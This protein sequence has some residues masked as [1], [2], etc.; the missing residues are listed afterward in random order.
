MK[1]LILK[2]ILPALGILLWLAICYPIS[3]RPEGF[4]Y[5]MFWILAGIPFGVRFMFLKLFPKGYGISGTVGMFALNV[6]AG[7]LIGGVF[8][9]IRVVRIFID[10][11]K[12]ILGKEV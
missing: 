1:N 6:M 3:K 9:L 11:I 4:N 12:I 2:V 8:L 5:F 7:A 10:T